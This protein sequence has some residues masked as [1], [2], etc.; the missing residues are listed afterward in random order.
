MTLSNY[1]LLRSSP[2]YLLW[3]SASGCCFNLCTFAWTLCLS[4]LQPLLFVLYLSS[5]KHR[6]FI[7]AVKGLIPT[8]PFSSRPPFTKIQPQSTVRFC[9]FCSEQCQRVSDLNNRVKPYVSVGLSCRSPSAVL[10]LGR[11]NKETQ[12]PSRTQAWPLISGWSQS[13]NRRG[14]FLSA[15]WTNA[16]SELSR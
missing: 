3:S 13:C 16:V 7:W 4:V 6:V 8:P 10:P 14:P 2:C 12:L 11:R 5:W 15:G 9:Y 1:F